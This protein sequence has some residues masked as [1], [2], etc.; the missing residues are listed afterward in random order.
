MMNDTSNV[1]KNN[2]ALIDSSKNKLIEEFSQCLMNKSLVYLDYPVHLNIGDLLIYEGV[3]RLLERLQSKVVA[4]FSVRNQNAFFDKQWDEDVILLFH[5]GGNFG[6]LYTHH[7]AF[8]E[9]AIKTFPNNKIIIMPQSVH[10]DN[11]N[12]LKTSSVIY[13]AHQDLHIFVRDEPSYH[14]LNQ[15]LHNTP[16]KI[17]PDTA[18][19]IDDIYAVKNQMNAKTLKLR[20]RDIESTTV[21]ASSTESF[22]WDD[23]ITRFDRHAYNFVTYLSRIEN[24]FKVKLF[25]EHLWL[26]LSRRIIKKAV[27][28]FKDYHVIDTDRLHGM[29]LALLMGCDVIKRDNSYGKLSRYSSFWLT[30]ESFDNAKMA[31]QPE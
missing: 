3:E 15:H 13:E 5:G 24:K 31:A 21:Q 28:F 27:N 20:R 8:R 10:Y 16:V 23:L 30:P 17:M 29:I 1:I 11:V 25:S 19:L 4:R 7:Q 26:Y 12:N 18:F 9:K 2:K 6:D 14:L 22:D